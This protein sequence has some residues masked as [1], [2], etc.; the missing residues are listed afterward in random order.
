MSFAMSSD[1]VEWVLGWIG[2]GLIAL[3]MVMGAGV[4]GLLLWVWR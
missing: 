4:Y 2:V 3:G 1:E